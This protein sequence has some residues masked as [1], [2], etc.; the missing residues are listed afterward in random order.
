MNIVAIDPSLASTAMVVN[1]KK[2]VY[3]SISTSRTKKLALKGW[4][5]KTDGLITLR[6]HNDTPSMDYMEGEVA[7]WKHFNEISHKIAAD[8][9]A[10]IDHTQSTVV[11]IEGY[12]FSSAAG[13]L[14]DLVTLGTLIRQKI[15]ELKLLANNNLPLEFHIISP[16]S[17]KAMVAKLTYPGVPKNKK[18]DLEYRNKEGVAGGS[19]K[20]HEMY[21]ALI[22]NE[23]L[24]CEYVE[25]LRE[26]AEEI[27]ALK[28]IP[29]PIEDTNDA[30]LLYEVIRAGL[31]TP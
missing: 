21:K 1:D 19:F 29:K 26:H 22:E 31:L 27:L 28:S 6:E 25:F 3:G 10:N 4:Y 11:A 15:I 13:P 23:S 5:E 2:F 18:G 7:K 30:K 8:I 14:I 20:K 17:L 9:H 12:S 24:K 16:T